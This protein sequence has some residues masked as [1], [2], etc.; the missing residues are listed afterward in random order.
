[1]PNKPSYE[2]LE[3]IINELENEVARLR[4]KSVFE[5]ELFQTN[6]AFIV[7]IDSE[8]K[9]VMMN[10]AMLDATGY[11]SEEVIGFDYMNNFVP[12]KDREM[13]GEVFKTLVKSKDSTVNENYISTKDGR[14]LLVEWHGNQI[15][16]K[17][18]EFKF[19][20]GVGVDIT[21][22]RKAEEALQQAEEKYR[23]I[24]E[25]ATEGIFQ[26]SLDGRFISVNQAMARIL[27]YDSPDELI[28]SITDIRKQF[29]V[30]P[31]FRNK[32][33]NILHKKD[34]VSNME[35]Q[36]QRKDGSAFWG[37]ESVRAVRDKNGE[38]LYYE[39]ILEDITERKKA[40]EATKKAKDAAEAAS[41]AKSDFIANMSHELRTPINGIIASADLALSHDLPNEV[42]Q[43]LETLHNSAH[44]LFGVI[45][46]ILDF[47]KSED[48]MV[49][50]QIYPFLLDETLEKLSRSLVQKGIK[51]QIKIDFQINP[52]EIPNALIGNPDRLCDILNQLLN[53]AAKF[54]EGEPTA[55]LGINVI[56]NSL[57]QA[58]LEFYIKDNGIGIAPKFFD[59]IFEHFTQVDTSSTRKFDGVGIGLSVCKRLVVLMGGKIRVESELGKGSTFYVTLPFMR[60]ELDQPFNVQCFQDIKD[61]IAAKSSI[62][63]ETFEVLDIEKITP[64]IDKLTK[65][66]E[67]MNP[68]EVKIYI[69]QFRNHIGSSKL[70][71]LINQIEDYEYEEAVKILKE[72][73]AENGVQTE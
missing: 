29:Y 30:D 13:L 23:S 39:G 48:L 60:Q 36:Y 8:G 54:T 71:E 16:D 43:I 65:A 62:D 2:E 1:M 26:S 44:S 55:I 46:G 40:A 41:Q 72:I 5:N 3:Q 45:T 12:K 35:I 19:F 58:I 11:T 63:D 57:E 7:A 31:E 53:N 17:N 33:N 42:K 9:A 32:L 68:G 51:K 70:K 52:D 47:S 37:T 67:N 22:P 10:N 28:S 21:D 20:F 61:N 59:K 38:L 34:K 50:L 56:E 14:K 64:I 49:E 25:N 18:D 73:V 69:D 4:E 15:F 27:G 6:P 24:F 66:L